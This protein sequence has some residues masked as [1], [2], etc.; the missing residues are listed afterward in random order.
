MTTIGIATGLP[1]TRLRLTRRGRRVLTGIVAFPVAVAIAAAVIGGGAALAS[2]EA[3]ASS[4]SFTTV[5]VG[6]GDSLWSIA[7]TVAPGADPRDVVDAIVHL[8][9]LDGVVVTPGEKLAIP[10]EYAPSH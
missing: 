1:A 2:H 4:G 10:A 5:T 9:A 8:N 3:G 7:E 6:A